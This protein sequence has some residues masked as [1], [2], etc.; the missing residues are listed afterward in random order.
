MSQDI[1]GALVAFLKADGA[2]AALV[3]TRVFGA[4]LPGSE[5]ASMPRKCVV[6]TPSGGP[7]RASGSYIEHVEQRIDAF[8]YGETIFEAES[9]R[10]AVA[11]AFMKQRRAVTG[12]TLIH[13]VESAGGWASQR[14]SDLSWPRAFQSFQAFYA[15]AAA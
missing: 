6:L 9:V 11:D 4:E 7:N 2:V 14:E 3:G 15:L 5:A 10:D 1:I 13:S 8:S 12:T